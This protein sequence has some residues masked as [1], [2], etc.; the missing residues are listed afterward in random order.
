MSLSRIVINNKIYTIKRFLVTLLLTVQ[1]RS[2]FGKKTETL[3]K[4]SFK[5]STTI[6]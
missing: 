6:S 3:N 2:R 5:T 1:I 4:L